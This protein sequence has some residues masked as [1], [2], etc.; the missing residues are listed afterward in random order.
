MGVALGGRVA[1]T[2]I[3]STGSLVA[4]TVTTCSSRRSWVVILSDCSLPEFL[5]HI[6]PPMNTEQ[7]KMTT[8]S[9]PIP[10][11]GN[12]PPAGTKLATI[13]APEPYCNGPRLLKLSSLRAEGYYSSQ[14]KLP[15]LACGL[16]PLHSQLN[17]CVRPPPCAMSLDWR[18]LNAKKNNILTSSAEYAS[19][20]I[21][22]RRY[23]FRCDFTSLARKEKSPS[24]QR[25]ALL[26]GGGAI[27]AVTQPSHQP[28]RG[29]CNMLAS[30]SVHR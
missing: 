1:I 6:M 16:A 26:H 13:I 12:P 30:L 9:A 25:E 23:A 29:Y 27:S 21:E 4:T 2:T 15:A 3:T 22:K 17:M 5:P 19:A 7:P 18:C 8:T 14:L 10:L 20:T 24:S 28:H 11:K